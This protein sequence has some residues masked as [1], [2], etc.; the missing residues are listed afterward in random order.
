MTGEINVVNIHKPESSIKLREA[1]S[2]PL[3]L[4]YVEVENSDQR[5]SLDHVVGENLYSQGPDSLHAQLQSKFGLS[6]RQARIAH[7]MCDDDFLRRTVES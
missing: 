1:A 2:D 3:L 6:K 7:R 4:R 5:G